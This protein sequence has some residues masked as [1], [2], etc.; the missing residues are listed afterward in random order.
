MPGR[1]IRWAWGFR[2][3]VI[4]PAPFLNVLNEPGLPQ[5]EKML[6]RGGRRQPQQ[7]G[8][9]ADA[10]GAVAQGHEYPDAALVP[11]GADQVEKGEH[12]F[13]RHHPG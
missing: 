2:Q 9:F 13:L 12:G 11:Q 3:A 1:R 10:Q 8:D 6:G 7:G 4:D 5:Q